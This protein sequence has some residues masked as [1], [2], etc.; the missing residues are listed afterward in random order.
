M[1]LLFRNQRDLAGAK[2]KRPKKENNREGGGVTKRLLLGHS[3]QGQSS[4]SEK[5]TISG[6]NILNFKRK[7]TRN[8]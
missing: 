2:F 3:K 8:R 6:Q 7:N 1:L 4:E 5:G